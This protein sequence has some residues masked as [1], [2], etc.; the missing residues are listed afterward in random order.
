MGS[1]ARYVMDDNA[2]AI[3]HDWCGVIWRV[4]PFHRWCPARSP[5]LNPTKRMWDLVGKTDCGSVL[6]APS[7]T[8]QALLQEW[9]LL[10]QQRSTTLLPTCLTFV[11]MHFS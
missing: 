6:Q 10:P 7:T 11:S 8:Q 5:D 3:E 9:A 2:Y 1:D 4:K